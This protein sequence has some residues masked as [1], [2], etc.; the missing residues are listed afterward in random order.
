MHPAQLIRI[1]RLPRDPGVGKVQ[2]RLLNDQ[3][4]LD[5]IKL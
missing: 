3:D 1:E 4:P 5:S 2:R